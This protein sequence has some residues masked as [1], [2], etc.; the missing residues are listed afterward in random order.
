MDYQ[1]HL[2]HLPAS[3]PAVTVQQDDF[4]NI[5]LNSSLDKA[6]QQKALAHEL[7]HLDRQ[8]FRDSISILE[9]ETYRASLPFGDS[10]LK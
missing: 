10:A 4:C 9:A 2:L 3:V 5:Y 1:V 6:G 8:D 7:A